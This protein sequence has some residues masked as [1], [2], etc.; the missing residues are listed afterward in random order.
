MAEDPE[1][2]EQ[3]LLDIFY[4][5]DAE[6]EIGGDF[7]RSHPGG[8]P[9]EDGG[10][11]FFQRDRPHGRCLPTLP[12]A[13]TRVGERPHERVFVGPLVDE[14][15]AGFMGELGEFGGRKAVVN[16]DQPPRRG[17]A[18]PVFQAAP[19]DSGWLGR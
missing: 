8:Y 5:A 17:P 19:P 16:A 10:L 13:M 2:H 4:G 7:G 18:L 6:P 3:R 9:A 12:G 11:P 15:G 14:G 1:P